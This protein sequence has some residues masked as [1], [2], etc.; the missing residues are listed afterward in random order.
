MNKINKIYYLGIPGSNS[1]L[2]ASMLAPKDK[3]LMGL[4]SFEEIFKQVQKDDRATGVLPVE[5]SLSGSIYEVY[6]LLAK[7]RTFIS[8]ELIV[9]INHTLMQQK[10]TSLSRIRRCL[11]HPEVFR[12]CRRFFL[13]HP[14][15]EL[16][17]VS[18]TASA[19]KMLKDSGPEFAAI[20]NP[21]AA[22]THNLKIVKEH[23]EDESPNFF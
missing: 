6:D 12:Q 1:Y 16:V 21:L 18:D 9:R 10:K 4:S 8:A 7:S 22:S 2:A 23:L 19:A 20:A 11:S 3:K 5:N 15:I 14:E 17:A 13:K